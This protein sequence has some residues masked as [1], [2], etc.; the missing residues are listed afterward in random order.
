MMKM[1][2]SHFAKYATAETLM[3]DCHVANAPL[4]DRKL[5]GQGAELAL[6]MAEING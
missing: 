6:A 4:N 3:P 2:H 1:P 5:I